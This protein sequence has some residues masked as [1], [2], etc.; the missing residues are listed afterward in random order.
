MLFLEVA[1]KPLR[2]E[3]RVWSL[4]EL[5]GRL[6]ESILQDA[7]CPSDPGSPK[8]GWRWGRLAMGTVPSTDEDVGE[9]G[10]WP[11]ESDC[12]LKTT[13]NIR[14]IPYNQWTSRL[15]LGGAAT[16]ETSSPHLAS[17]RRGLLTCLFVMFDL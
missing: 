3:A 15:T 16:L 1:E 12:K 4:Q 10:S 2:V 11:Q 6:L 7:Q 9:S 17:E 8:R 13:T 14:A 5:A